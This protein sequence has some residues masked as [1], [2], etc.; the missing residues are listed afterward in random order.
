VSLVCGKGERGGLR[1]VERGGGMRKGEE[2]GY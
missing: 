2:G 1:G